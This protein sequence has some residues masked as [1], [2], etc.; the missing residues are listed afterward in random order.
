[1]FRSILS[2]FLAVFLV[3]P[4]GVSAFEGAAPP[5][6]ERPPWKGGPVFW[7]ALSLL[8]GALLTSSIIDL[9]FYE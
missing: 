3:L 2:L 9:K 5:A 8:N 1:M 4:Q 7:G 6:E